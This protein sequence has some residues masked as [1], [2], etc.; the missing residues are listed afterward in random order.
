MQALIQTYM[1]EIIKKNE[2]NVKVY[3]D[4]VLLFDSLH[5]RC[6]RTLVW[7]ELTGDQRRQ[8]QEEIEA[9]YN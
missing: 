1:M 9:N 5:P 2:D 3:K 8:R 6:E 4:G 7:C